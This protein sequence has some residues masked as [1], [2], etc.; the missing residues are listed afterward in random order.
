MRLTILIMVISSSTALAPCRIDV[1]AGDNF[2]QIFKD[3]VADYALYN[4]LMQDSY[5]F[6]QY[7]ISLHASSPTMAVAYL[8]EG[9]SLPLAQCIV[10]YYLQWLPEHEC[11]AIIPT[12]SIPIITA[13]DKAHLKMHRL[14][15]EVVVLERIYTNCYEMGDKYLYKITACLKESRW[16]VIDLQFDRLT[17]GNP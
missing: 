4:S 12:E 9:F 15:P 3:L 2:N 17:T 8:S 1:S 5:T 11:I 6:N 14:S 13:A 10:D 16:I 7:N